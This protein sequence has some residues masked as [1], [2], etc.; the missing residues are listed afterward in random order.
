MVN[1]SKSLFHLC[2]IKA[3]MAALDSCST[4]PMAEKGRFLMQTI[5]K[6]LRHWSNNKRQLNERFI[7]VFYFNKLIN[8]GFFVLLIRCRFEVRLRS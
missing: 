7:G 8:I 2:S 4:L 1:L 6:S 5:L 3:F